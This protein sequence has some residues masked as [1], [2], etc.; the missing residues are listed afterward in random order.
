M[1]AHTLTLFGGFGVN[2]FGVEPEKETRP[3]RQEACFDVRM[4]L[5]IFRSCWQRIESLLLTAVLREFDDFCFGE[6]FQVYWWACLDKH[7]RCEHGAR[8]P[9]QQRVK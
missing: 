3:H 6:S 4:P 2:P 7:C 1:K 5:D 9:R 8:A